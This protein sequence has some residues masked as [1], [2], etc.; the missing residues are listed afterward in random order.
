MTDDQRTVQ[1]LTNTE[2]S[3]DNSEKVLGMKWDPKQDVILYDAEPNFL[4]GKK[5][6]SKQPA[7]YVSKIPAYIPLNL[8]KRHFCL[9]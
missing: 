1:L 6:H 4:N 9:K 3:E 8:T 2:V 5:E 7:K